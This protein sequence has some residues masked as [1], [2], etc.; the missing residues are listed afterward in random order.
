[1]ITGPDVLLLIWAVGVAYHA[2]RIL[3]RLSLITTC[4]PI[5]LCQGC[6]DERRNVMHE[7]MTFEFLGA[8]GGPVMVL[9]EA[10]IW[11]L[12]PFQPALRRLAGREPLP[13]CSKGSC[14][15]HTSTRRRA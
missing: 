6:R 7:G 3:K 15:A 9:L 10:N 13:T 14:L 8:A 2:P 1:M 11:Y 12:K 4:D 5:E